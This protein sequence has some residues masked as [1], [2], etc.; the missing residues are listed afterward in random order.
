[1]YNLPNELVKPICA[2]PTYSS[3]SGLKVSKR[4]ITILKNIKKSNQQ[5]VYIAV[6]FY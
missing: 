5:V 3:V 1:M 2:N 4:T 6:K